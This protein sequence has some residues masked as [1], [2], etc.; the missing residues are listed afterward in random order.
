MLP[1]VPA[2]VGAEERPRQALR[3]DGGARIRRRRVRGP[4]D[5]GGGRRVLPADAAGEGVGHCLRAVVLVLGLVLVVRGCGGAY[6]PVF[7]RACL[8][9]CGG[10]GG[11][12]KRAWVEMLRRDVES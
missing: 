4:G 7:R 10:G 3:G 11:G 8:W 6:Q 12:A 1:I 9:C 5:V 2:E